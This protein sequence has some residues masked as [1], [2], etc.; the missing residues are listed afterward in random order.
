M[1]SGSDQNRSGERQLAEMTTITN[2]ARSRE[3][4]SQLRIQTVESRNSPTPRNIHRKRVLQLNETFDTINW[5]GFW[6]KKLEASFRE[7]TQT[8]LD[9]FEVVSVDHRFYAEKLISILQNKYPDAEFAAENC[10]GSWGIYAR[11][12]TQ[13]KITEKKLSSLQE[14][15]EAIY[16][17]LMQE[18]P[19]ATLP[20]EKA[21]KSERGCL[22][23]LLVFLVTMA[24]GIV[25]CF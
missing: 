12:R 25:S 21:S 5:D 8:A 14:D 7:R 13:R 3:R 19:L 15:A 6:Q 11:T 4:C 24:I 10:V 2:I 18:S 9:G 1:R 17:T 16:E 23:S 20:R 22:S